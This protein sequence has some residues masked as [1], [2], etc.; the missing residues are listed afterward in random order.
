[1]TVEFTKDAEFKRV[2]ESKPKWELFSSQSLV[3]A[4]KEARKLGWKDKQVQ[5]RWEREDSII[6]YKV[7]PFEKD[8][9]CNSMLK[10]SDF[11][12]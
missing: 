6:I 2:H 10:Y 3:Q 7:E 12:D 4:V 11:F 5:V 1:M 9:N 8:C